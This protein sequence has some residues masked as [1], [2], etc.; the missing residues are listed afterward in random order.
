MFENFLS[1]SKT[2]NHIFLEFKPQ[3]FTKAMSS[4]K[5][6]KSVHVKLSCYRGVPGLLFDM[7]V[8]KVQI[9]YLRMLR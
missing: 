8:G 1:E 4:S 7:E 6:T 9:R 5:S 2:D 3:S